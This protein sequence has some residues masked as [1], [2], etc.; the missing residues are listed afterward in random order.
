MSGAKTIPFKKGCYFC[1]NS[2]VAPSWRNLPA[3]KPI[4]YPHFDA[5][6]ETEGLPP[7]GMA[8][9]YTDR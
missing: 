9:S 8:I 5:I 2:S 6:E 1:E 4:C 7:T 3:D